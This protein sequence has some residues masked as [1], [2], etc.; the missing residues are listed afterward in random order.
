MKKF[1]ES[2]VKV[3]RLNEPDIE[4]MAKA[5]RKHYLKEG[6]VDE[7]KQASTHENKINSLVEAHSNIL[8]FPNKR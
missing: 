7:S 2:Q 6:L 5:F 4:L 8:K 3:I 1:N